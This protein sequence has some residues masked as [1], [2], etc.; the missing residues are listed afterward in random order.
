MD[1]AGAAGSTAQLGSVR[2]VAGNQKRRARRHMRAAAGDQERR[3]R[4]GRRQRAAGSQRRT[5][6]PYPDQAEAAAPHPG[7]G[8]GG[9]PPPRSGG[10]R[11]GSDGGE[12]PD[13]A[14][15]MATVMTETATVATTA[16]ARKVTAVAL[17][18][19][20]SFFGFYFFRFFYFFRAG[21]IYNHPARENQIFH[22]ACKNIDFYRRL[23][24]QHVKITF[25]RTE[26]SFLYQ[27]QSPNFGGNKTVN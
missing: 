18:L 17:G 9:R 11:V 25:D 6:T 2:A 10:G 16:T 3:A 20:F 23:E 5:T 19:R 4:G 7:F 14:T 22:V 26:K 1:G 12:A 27:W 15:A 13:V 8:G 24:E 21:D